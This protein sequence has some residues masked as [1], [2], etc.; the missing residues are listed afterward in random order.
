MNI[1]VGPLGVDRVGRGDIHTHAVGFYGYIPSRPVQKAH[2]ERDV[3]VLISKWAAQGSVQHSAVQFRAAVEELILG[4]L[5]RSG[6]P[7]AP[8]AKQGLA[9]AS[10]FFGGVQHF[11][12]PG[13]IV[14]GAA[15][16]SVFG[17]GISEN[18]PSSRR[19]SATG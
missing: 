1:P 19:S 11:I 12:S 4:V 18:I 6:G 14:E 5:S 15:T 16:V 3:S 17:S 10:V 8:G 2:A 9:A 7:D 13:P